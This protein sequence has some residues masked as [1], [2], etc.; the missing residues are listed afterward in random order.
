[1]SAIPVEPVSPTIRD[2]HESA[3]LHEVVRSTACVEPAPAAQGARRPA[4]RGWAARAARLARAHHLRH[5]PLPALPMRT[6]ASAWSRERLA[7]LSLPRVPAQLQRPHRHAACATGWP[8]S[9]AWPRATCRTT[10]AGAECSMAGKSLLLI[11]CFAL[12]S[13]PS[14]VNGDSA[15]IN[16]RGHAP[17]SRAQHRSAA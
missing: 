8:P 16:G 3:A 9:T 11:N 10:W 14:T 17:A 6:L 5:A 4:A 7:A 15:S 2:E 13:A 1:M 12:L